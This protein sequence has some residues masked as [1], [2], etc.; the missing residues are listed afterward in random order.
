MTPSIYLDALDAMTYDGQ[1]QFAFFNT[2]G[3]DLAFFEEAI[4]PRLWRQGCRNI[5]IAMD[6]RRYDDTLRDLRGSFSWVGRRYIVLP[7]DM[8]GRQS[9]HPK[10]YLLIGHENGRLLVG[11][12]NLNFRGI[13]S[14]YES[15]TVLD[16]TPEN[17]SFGT[18]ISE[19][20]RMTRRVVEDLAHSGE[21]RRLVDKCEHV[22]PWV[23]DRPADSPDIHLLHTL[24]DSLFDQCSDLIQGVEIE[25]ITLSS[26]FIDEKAGMLQH[27]HRRFR[28]PEIKLIV[29]MGQTSGNVESL[30]RLKQSGVP[31]KIFQASQDDRYIHAKIYCFEGVQS[32]YL[33]TGSPNCTR[34]AWLHS[35]EKGNFEAGILHRSDEAGHFESFLDEIAGSAIEKPLDRLDLRSLDFPSDEDGQRSIHLIDLQILG[36][37]LLVKLDLFGQKGKTEE[38]SIVF[39]TTPIIAASLGSQSSGLHEI[40]MDLPPA[41]A[42]K[43]DHPLSAKICG[44]DRDGEYLDLGCNE[45]WVTNSNALRFEIRRSIPDHDQAGQ[46]LAEMLVTSENEWEELYKTLIDLVALDVSRLKR[47]GGTYTSSPREPNADGILPEE[48]ETPVQIVDHAEEEREDFARTL[49]LESSVWAW[50]EYVSSTMPGRDRTTDSQ[51]AEPKEETPDPGERRRLATRIPPSD[52]TKRRFINLVKKF[53]ASLR[54]T[55]Y[56]ELVSIFHLFSYF[57]I[58]HRL[59][60]LMLKH[61]AIS[62]AQY[63]QLSG[64]INEGLFGN[65]DDP[66][67]SLM[68]GHGRFIRRVW[69]QDWS[70]IHGTLYVIASMTFSERLSQS[71]GTNRTESGSKEQR[72][73]LLAALS[74]L[75][76]P[77]TWFADEEANNEVATVFEVAENSLAEVGKII[78]SSDLPAILYTLDR[79]NSKTTER[80]EAEAST[81]VKWQ[82]YLSK[83]DYRLASYD[84][85]SLLDE[86]DQRIAIATDIA[87]YYSIVGN[88]DETQ[89]WERNLIE[90]LRTKGDT[91]SL[92]SSLCKH[93]RSLIRSDQPEEAQRKLRQS[94]LLAEECGDISLA[95]RCRTFLDLAELLSK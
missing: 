79:W 63:T 42:K 17:L 74:V 78:R 62:R 50:M 41:L 32:A 34:A 8:G 11:S 81:A 33:L 30:E 2:Y 13:G 94:V 72:V 21:A 52:R 70:L 95:K 56:M 23:R 57:V 75:A 86:T 93:G 6:R 10:L 38:L 1:Y 53:I 71:V 15:F 28:S 59:C 45:I 64:Q 61:G 19:A 29:Q 40:K 76:D 88:R 49:F 4:L 66:P 16:R 60:R 65:L 68:R 24:D 48:T 36:K 58:F 5:L 85:A 35:A 80:L 25:T 46:A 43:L 37:S 3:V 69:S 47:K 55:E 27:L 91:R 67:P 90:L 51:P 20:W 18:I 73:R 39:S 92:A 77:K 89:V 9:Y 12:G 31:L 82:L 44:I 7:I 87:R 22:A 14:N 84:I 26:P 83:I 54:N